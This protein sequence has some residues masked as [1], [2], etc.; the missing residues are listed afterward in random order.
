VV[1]GVLAEH[2]LERK[3]RA[4]ESLSWPQALLSFLFPS[5]VLQFLVAELYFGQR[6]YA[7]KRK[8]FW[9]WGL[10]GVIFQLVLLAACRQLERL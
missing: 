10:Y 9:L 3:L 6:G 7:R 2:S 8:E 1:E 5:I 4:D